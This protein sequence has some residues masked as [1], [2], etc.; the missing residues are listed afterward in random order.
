VG[1]AR[2]G[3]AVKHARDELVEARE[4]DDARAAVACGARAAKEQYRR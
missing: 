2:D 1:E 4:H 3:G